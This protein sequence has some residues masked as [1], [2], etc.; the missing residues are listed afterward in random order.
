MV[1]KG[2]VHSIHK[3]TD[4]LCECSL[5]AR[6]ICVIMLQ[7]SKG[8]THMV[9]LTFRTEILSNKYNLGTLYF[10]FTQMWELLTV[11]LWSLL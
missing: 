8:E 5:V 3:S 4:Y 6:G 10:T 11:T 2:I 9:F 1:Y 7:R